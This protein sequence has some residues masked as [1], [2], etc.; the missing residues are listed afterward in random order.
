[1]STCLCLAGPG[2]VSSAGWTGHGTNTY[3]VQVEFRFLLRT[4]LK[5]DAG[6]E[7]RIS[8]RNDLENAI[9]GM[10]TDPGMRT[11]FSKTYSG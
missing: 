6:K 7:P 3:L 4:R 2:Y 8:K 10:C 1:M 11:L 5:C 9:D